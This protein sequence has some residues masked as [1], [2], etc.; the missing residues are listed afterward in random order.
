MNATAQQANPRPAP[1]A[2]RVAPR[3]LF[4]GL[5]GGPLAWYVQLCAGFALASQPCFRGG[6]RLA[7]PLR[8]AQWTWPAMIL[9]MISAVVVALLALLVSSRAFRRTRTEGSGDAAHLSEV[10]TGRT[11]YLALWGVLLSAAFALA[12]AISAVAFITVPRCA[13]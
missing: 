2:D 6:M 1:H 13:G 3:E 8:G 9:I 7:A 10:G 5:W 4:F 11:R 12:A